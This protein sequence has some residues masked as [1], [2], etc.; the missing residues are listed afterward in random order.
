MS[1]R[2]RRKDRRRNGVYREV[3]NEERECSGRGGKEGGVKK[4]G[5]GGGGVERGNDLVGCGSWE[6][7]GRC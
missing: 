3:E 4:G 1:D 5:G 2:G 6:R 7:L